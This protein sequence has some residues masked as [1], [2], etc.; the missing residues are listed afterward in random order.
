[1]YL[2]P[3]EGQQEKLFFFKSPFVPSVTHTNMIYPNL[4]VIL[5]YKLKGIQFIE[6]F[7]R[8]FVPS[9]ML[10]QDMQTSYLT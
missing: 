10:S 6:C 9:L 2:S 1:M 5:K 8:G 4:R 3:L 7:L